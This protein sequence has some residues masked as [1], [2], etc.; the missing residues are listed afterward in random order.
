MMLY[1][2]TPHKDWRRMKEMKITHEFRY[3]NNPNSQAFIESH[4][5]AI[6]L[7]VSSPISLSHIPPK[8]RSKIL[9]IYYHQKT[10]IKIQPLH[11]K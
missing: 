3:K 4:H 1:I 10:I 6:T 9:L 8:N 11:L 5:K 7:F 2:I